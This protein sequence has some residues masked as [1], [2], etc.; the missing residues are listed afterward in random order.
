MTNTPL[1]Y[2]SAPSDAMSWFLGKYTEGVITCNI[3]RESLVIGR[4]VENWRVVH[5][6][7]E[8]NDPHIPV[9]QTCYSLENHLVGVIKMMKQ[10]DTI[11]WESLVQ[12]TFL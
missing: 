4:T 12:F 7:H 10:R 5:N 2:K 11:K 9:K 3:I 1:V 6:P 8:A